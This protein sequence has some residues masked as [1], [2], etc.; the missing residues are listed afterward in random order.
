M[1][2]VA[3]SAARAIASFDRET[4]VQTRMALLQAPDGGTA[5]STWRCCKLFGVLHDDGVAEIN[6]FGE[7]DVC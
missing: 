4:C 1:L 5:S 7:V 2:R 6:C 3:G